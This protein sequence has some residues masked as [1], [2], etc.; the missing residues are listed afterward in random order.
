MGKNHLHILWT[1]DNVLTAENMVMLYAINA[2]KKNWWEEVT[3]IIWGATAKIAVEDEKLRSLI[4]DGIE[5]GVH[6]SACK[7]CADKLGTT[8]QLLAMG[9]EVL[10]WGE[11]LT[12]L[13]KDAQPLLT[14]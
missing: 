13:I 6:F 4:Q 10:Y 8:D 1:N 5:S 7:A 3:V 12:K 14:I 11:P 9:V 2:K